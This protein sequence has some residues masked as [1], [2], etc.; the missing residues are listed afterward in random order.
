M[1][2]NDVKDLKT[3][4][5][6]LVILL[7]VVLAFFLIAPGEMRQPPSSPASRE[8]VYPP[9]P[10]PQQLAVLK[11]MKPFQYLVSYTDRGFEPPALAMKRGD[12]VRFVNNSSG[13]LWVAA[14]G[15]QEHPIYP[16]TSECGGSSFD[17]CKALEPG[18]FWQF[19]FDE[20][21]LWKYQNNVDKTKTGIVRVQ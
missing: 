8:R 18:D 13:D 1:Y 4:I 6:A 21:G 5:T 17:S 10:T 19:T 14:A 15:A 9:A 7:L 2:S 20:S 3:P 12:T 11:T 16:G